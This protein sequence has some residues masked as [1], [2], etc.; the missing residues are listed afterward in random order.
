MPSFSG[1]SKQEVR[2]RRV[3]IAAWSIVLVGVAVA[4]VGRYEEL[5]ERQTKLPAR[6]TKQSSGYT[7]APEVRFILAHGSELGLTA[8]QVSRLKRIQFE[9]EEEVRFAWPDVLAASREVSTAVS[10]KRST[11]AELRAR[12]AEVSA[13]SAELALRR[14][15]HWE[16]AVALLTARQKE[17]LKR[18][19]AQVTLQDLM[20]TGSVVGKSTEEKQK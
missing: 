9:W 10:G 17:L 11:E 16:N 15:K 5:K 7:P 4:L 18:L 3:R 8:S 1:R 2:I 19:L 14:R 20:P 12:S 6:G 13:L